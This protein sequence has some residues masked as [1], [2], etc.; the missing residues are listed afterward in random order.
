MTDWT[1]VASTKYNNHDNG[2]STPAISTFGANLIVAE[3]RWYSVGTEPALS[4]SKTNNWVPM[5]ARAEAVPSMRMYYCINPTVSANGVTDHTFAVSGTGNVPDVHVLALKCSAAGSVAY[6]TSSEKGTH[7]SSGTSIQPGA[8]TPS[9]NK[10]VM[11]VGCESGGTAPTIDSSFTREEVD[12]YVAPSE[13]GG[14]I[15]WK[16]KATPGSENPTVSW[17][18]N[19]NNSACISMLTFLGGVTSPLA[20][21]TT[22]A[23]D[24]IIPLANGQTYTDVTFA[25]VYDISLG[26][27]SSIK[28][29]SYLANGTT[30][31]SSFFA[32]QSGSWS[33]GNGSATF[34][35]TW[36]EHK[37][38]ALRT[39]DGGSSTLETSSVTATAITG[40]GLVGAEHGQSNEEK[41]NTVISSPPAADS[42]AKV[43]NGT[44]WASPAGNG[45]VALLN[46]LVSAAGA[47]ATGNK[48]PCGMAL[49]AVGGAGWHFTSGGVRWDDTT[50]SGTTWAGYVSKTGSLRGGKPNYTC[51]DGGTSDATNASPAATIVTNEGAVRT[52]IL[53]LHSLTAAQLPWFISVNAG[54]EGGESDADWDAAS[55]A[56]LI[57]HRDQTNAPIGC[58]IRDLPISDGS[59]HISA[60]SYARK[61]KRMGQTIANYFGLVSNYDGGS[62]TATR[63]LRASGSNDV[64]I[65]ITMP[66]GA[67]LKEL[68]GTT[69]GVGLTGWEGSA[70]SF[71]SVLTPSATAFTFGQLGQTSVQQVK[72]TFASV[73]TQIRYQYGNLSSNADITSPVYDDTAPGGD[74]IGRALLP[75]LGALTVITQY[76]ATAA[77]GSFTLTGQAAALKAGRTLA[78]TQASY[79]LSG[80]VAALKASRLLTPAQG[81]Y[82]L[83]GQNAVLVYTPA[84]GPTYTLTCSAGSYMLVGR[85]VSLLQSSS[86]VRPRILVSAG[87]SVGVDYILLPIGAAIDVGFDWTEWLDGYTL[88]SSEWEIDPASGAPTLSSDGNDTEVSGVTIEAIAASFAKQYELR[89]I[90]TDSLGRAA[91]RGMTLRVG[92]RT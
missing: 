34:R 69:D 45:M 2:G 7:Q 20:I 9:A 43:W 85:S 88:I 12:A 66:G 68:D 19:V 59:Y 44:S 58:S 71:S 35:L 28:L 31:V 87:P 27:P 41:M 15:A 39:F 63:A 51:G 67:A 52:N 17:S 86:F 4:D 78:A 14:L 37:K 65:N 25:F 74:T 57:F 3:V 54:S 23:A 84:G 46:Y 53:T 64:Y 79:G 60:A 70:N 89:N 13:F 92:Y 16:E 77:Q 33:N 18:T 11:V 21:T 61:G 49:T 62:V 42:C 75:T 83:S 22:L 82:A 80:Q 81:S 8:Y 10:A 91:V 55:Q 29:Q 72:L 30:V 76:T 38:F 36:D 32:S 40:T 50:G 5:T 90:V 48:K 26:E 56:D 47:S 24:E 6:D 1:K 73:P